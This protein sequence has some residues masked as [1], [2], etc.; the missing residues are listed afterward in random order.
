MNNL[1]PGAGKTRKVI[2]KLAKAHQDD[3][4]KLVILTPT[5]VVKA[6]VEK[7]LKENNISYG[8]SRHAYSGRVV[9]VMCH[10]TWARMLVAAPF[11]R[12]VSATVVMDESHFL[13]TW[14]IVARGLMEK[15]NL[16]GRA[17]QAIQDFGIRLDP[18]AVVKELLHSPEK[19]V[20]V[21]VPTK[22]AVNEWTKLIPVSLNPVGLYREA[23]ET[24]DPLA[25]RPTTRWIVTT[26]ISEMGANFGADICVDTGKTN[27]PVVSDGRVTLQ[28]GE[29]S[30]ASLI[31]R[32]GR[33]GRE[34]AGTYYYPGTRAEMTSGVRRNDAN[35]HGASQP[36]PILG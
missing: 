17:I 3:E 26:N 12:T 34:N 28:L 4:V 13:D 29:E 24:V 15:H 30:I 1:H 23:F 5:R 6:E 35:H 14:S 8:D 33:V 18:A 11:L 36:L 16:E 19:K 31:Q 20:I 22:K 10:A 32:R 9:N 27:V 2:L 21:F 25:A 7:V